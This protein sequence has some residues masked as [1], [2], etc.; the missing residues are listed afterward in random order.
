MND[1]HTQNILNEVRKT[2]KVVVCIFIIFM[3][4][5]AISVYS[6][7]H[8]QL[9]WQRY[10]STPDKTTMSWH[11][12]QQ[13]MDTGDF[14][15]AL[16]E[17]EKNVEEAPDYFRGYKILGHIYLAMRQPIKAEES[18]SKAYDLFP[19]EENLKNLEAVQKINIQ[20]N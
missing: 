8:S 1:D 17:A 2:R 4:Y 20:Q 14:E 13:I 16:T 3:I 15:L 6:F 9:R 7:I 5:F 11:V 10:S 19:S 12:V 18:F